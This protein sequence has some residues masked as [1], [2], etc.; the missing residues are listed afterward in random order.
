MP[1]RPLVLQN[2]LDKKISI[3]LCDEEATIRL[4]GV[5]AKELLPGDFIL[6]EG[7]LGAG[8]TTLARAIIQNLTG[9]KDLEVPSPSFALV[10]PYLTSDQTIIH[11]DLY[12]LENP[13]EIEEL[14]LFDD[15]DAII[16]VEW[17]Q[18]APM[19]A[20]YANID[21]AIKMGAGGE[22]R[23]ADITYSDRNAGLEILKRWQ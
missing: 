7:A 17:P 11:A 19:L 16:L 20:K 4:G 18:R 5:L 15:E 8:K 12:R 22:R 21:I 9:I 10:Q 6:L 14:G 3:D 1:D 13:D 2:K 23:L